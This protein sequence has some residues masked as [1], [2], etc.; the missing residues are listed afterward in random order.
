MLKRLI[1]RLSQLARLRS[2]DDDLREE[3]AHH[4]A[5]IGAKLEEQGL[6]PSE[7]S[8]AARRA[9]GNETYMREESR[10]VWLWPSIENVLQDVRYALRGLRRSPA[11]A[12]VAVL[13]LALGIGA[14]TTI[15]GLIH[16]LLLARV[17]VSAPEQLISLRRSLGAKGVDDQFSRAEFEA[18]ASSRMSLSMFASRGTSIDLDGVTVNVALDAVDGRY[19]DLLGIRAA[20][21]RLISVSDN[22]TS[23]QIAV[24]TDR[25]WH[26][27]FNADPAVLGRMMKISGQQFIIAGVMPPRFAGIRFPAFNDIV[28]PYATATSLG[29]IREPDSHQRG[30]TIVGRRSDAQTLES[31][32][33]ELRVIWSRCCASGGLVTLPKGFPP[34]N[35]QLDV[36]DISRGIPQMKL[37]LRGQYSRILMAL[38]AGVAIL[39]LGA[40]ANVANLL[41]ARST[42]RAGELAVRLALGASRQRLMMQLVTESLLLAVFGAIGGW[43][44][45]DGSSRILLR[46][47]IG[48]L[49][50]VVAPPS[51]G[52]ILLFT[53]GVSIGSAIIFGVIPAVRVLRTDLIASIKQGARRS[54]RRG[55]S[56]LD[57][58]LVAVQ[59]ALALLLVS[60]AALLV[61]TL[62][63]LE[64]SDLGFDPSGRFALNAETRG[65][66]YEKQLITAQTTNEMLLRVR[67]IPG[68]KSAG[69][70]SL[71]PIYGGR[72][73]SDLVSVRGA[74]PLANGD[75]D[76]WFIGVTPGYFASLGIPLLAG[77]DIDPPVATLSHTAARNVVIND[78]FAKK[79][80]ADRNPLGQT[81]QDHDDG[82]TVFTENRVVG[83]VGNAKFIGLRDPAQPA[84]FVP[85]TD[86]DWRYLV[87]VVRPASGA[88]PLGVAVARAIAAAAPGIA[89]GDPES[90][91][92]SIDAGLVRERMSAT[93][94]SLFGLMALSLVAVGLYGVMLYQ[95]TE[96]TTE[97]GIRIALGAR[98]TSVIN[99]VLRQS[100][101]IVGIGIAVGAPLA[102]LAGRA[103]ASQLYAVAP[104]DFSA[105][106]ISAAILVAVAIAAS[107]VPVRRAVTVDP[108]TALRAD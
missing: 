19:F 86:H 68:V 13:S 33:D 25:F 96:R 35:A 81:F 50:A 89:I 1:R 55:R 101:G 39:L 48:D 62:R 24:I 76:T 54:G 108:I 75:A 21:G 7:A 49:S 45:A 27:R 80:F 17:P 14:N 82:D 90:L 73:V 93:L 100:L 95:V 10:A 88:P 46:V 22:A 60:G 47:G 18:L 53:T 77:R 11:F 5:L 74:A 61:Q 64:G 32:R 65:T 106:A 42:S 107:L 23:A 105:L 30:V 31:A 34:G 40:C 104:Y 57:R 94:A 78:K 72:G 69:F 71:V 84:Y 52:G 20:R 41:L 63:N 43:L 98:G 2:A 16:S 9:M 29:I 67:A 12:V 28:I 92:A 3:L 91:S 97:F 36:I 59:I 85:V 26:G 58:G 87:V 66:S 79:F 8:D 15:F 6:S 4:R 44:L 103:V 56:W 51:G 37:D 70:G 99:L 83:V 38:M 102:I